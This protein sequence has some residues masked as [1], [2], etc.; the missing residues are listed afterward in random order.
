MALAGIIL[1]CWPLKASGVALDVVGNRDFEPHISSCHHWWISHVAF[2]KQ[3][4][5]T[6]RLPITLRASPAPIG[7]REG[8]HINKK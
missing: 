7:H 4:K 5:G 2:E 6:I 3:K 1:N 8:Q